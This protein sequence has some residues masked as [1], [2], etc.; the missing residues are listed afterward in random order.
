MYALFLIFPNCLWH[1]EDHA[2][3]AR[4]QHAESNQSKQ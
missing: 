1:A 3:P 4:T 2:G